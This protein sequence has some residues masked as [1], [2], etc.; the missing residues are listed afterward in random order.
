M[1]H[2]SSHVG[3]GLRGSGREKSKQAVETTMLDYIRKS[4]LNKV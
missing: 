3:K 1:P 4:E 2:E